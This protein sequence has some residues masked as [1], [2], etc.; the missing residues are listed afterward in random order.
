MSTSNIGSF[1]DI[2][3]D[4]KGNLLDSDGNI[5]PSSTANST[6]LI[7]PANTTNAILTTSGNWTGTSTVF[8][9]GSNGTITEETRAINI[10]KIAEMDEAKRAI[11]MS[12]ISEYNKGG[13]ET[14]KIFEN[15]LEAYGVFENKD[16]L[17]RKNKIG[18]V[19]K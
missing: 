15:T 1:Y 6:T 3:V 19:L 18:D 4:S 16:S 14:K 7:T 11:I 17:T 5:I 10:D 9:T 8:S 13:W 12:V 2:N